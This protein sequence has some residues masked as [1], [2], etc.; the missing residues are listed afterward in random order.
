MSDPR[1][2]SKFAGL[3]A[4]NHRRKNPRPRR[5][6]P[7]KLESLEARVL[8][9]ADLG[10]AMSV[11]DMLNSPTF[12]NQQAVVQDVQASQPVVASTST[13]PVLML[14]GSAAPSTI[15]PG[16]TMTVNVANP[17]GNPLD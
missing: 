1:Y 11:A 2:L 14:N 15:A 16:G 8:L 12:G 6:S 5:S 13:T 10:G 9:S 7:F 4:G 3:L 17:T